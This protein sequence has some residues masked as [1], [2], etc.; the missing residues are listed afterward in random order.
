[1]VR[2]KEQRVASGGIPADAR[3]RVQYVG[4]HL[5]GGDGQ[6]SGGQGD[7]AS[8]IR[9]FARTDRSSHHRWSRIPLP[10]TGNPELASLDLTASPWRIA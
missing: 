5:V 3:L 6:V 7:A 4:Q 9:P 2:L 8:T 10:A 1:M